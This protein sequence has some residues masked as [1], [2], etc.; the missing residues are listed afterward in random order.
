MKNLLCF[1]FTLCLLFAQRGFSQPKLIKDINTQTAD[2]FSTNQE[3][4]GNFGNYLFFKPTSG[5]SESRFY[6]DYEPD[7]WVT[8]G[9]TNG[10]V[11]IGSGSIIKAPYVF[12]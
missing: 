1:V 4:V 10:T 6:F 12:E 5:L 3:F 11:K 2:A 8:D 9:T 7:L